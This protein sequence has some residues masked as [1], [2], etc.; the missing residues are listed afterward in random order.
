MNQTLFK[1]GPFQIC[2]WNIIFLLLI[3][4]IAFVVR[5][6]LSTVLKR[7]LRSN[8]IQIEGKR[9][10]FITLLTQSVYL[11]AIYVSVLSFKFNNQDITFKDF[12]RYK[13]INSGNFKISLYNILLVIAS[14]IVA[15]MVINFIKLYIARRFRN[16]ADYDSGTE[17]VYIQ[18]AKYVI[19]LVTLFVCFNILGINLS[20]ILTGSVGLL[21]GLGLGLQDLFKDLVAGIVLL[22]ERNI[23]VGDIVE[24]SASGLKDSNSTVAKILKI[25]IRTTQIVTRDGN[26]LIIPN[27][28]FTQN[29][30][31]NWSHGSSLTRFSIG[32]TVNYGCDTETVKRLLT[33]AAMS[34]PKVNKAEPVFVRLSQFADSGLHFE[35]IFWAD[36]NWDINNYKSDIRYE[37]DRLFREYNIH[38][39]YPT[40]T[41]HILKD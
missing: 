7:T 41:L 10:T 32:V 23:K 30:V 9:E 15:R 34:H 21:V 33:Q 18:L 37:I 2:F 17:Y 39:P 29:Q 3:F 4:L 40:Q 1:I 38:I 36:Q 11:I 35:L 22:V 24:I 12:I 25:N 14:I 28:K 31:E 16:R 5:R 6:L 13:L 26:V 27:T 19:Y 20:L 8:N